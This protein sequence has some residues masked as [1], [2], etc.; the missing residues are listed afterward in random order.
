MKSLFNFHPLFLL[1]IGVLFSTSSCKRQPEG[2][3]IMQSP[4]L[5]IRFALVDKSANNICNTKENSPYNVDE[6]YVIMHDG[7]R[8]T[9]LQYYLPSETQGY[10]YHPANR[11][12]VFASEF[13]HSQTYK[14]SQYADRPF[15]LVLSNEDTDTLMWN[16]TE[17]WLY[18]NGEKA[19]LDTLGGGS[20]YMLVKD[21]F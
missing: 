13:L 14:G 1:L 20:P 18:H 3:P 9:D 11:G 16:S 6:I 4:N 10:S 5:E 17:E 15:Y 21:N 12:I 2:E 8:A 7:V 19:W